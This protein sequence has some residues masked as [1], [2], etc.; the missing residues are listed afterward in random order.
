MKL[1]DHAGAIGIVDCLTPSA[2]HLP[3]LTAHCVKSEF[4]SVSVHQEK[5]VVVVLVDPN[6]LLEAEV[7]IPPQK[8]RVS[9]WLSDQAERIIATALKQ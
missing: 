8:R 5:D 4:G 1:V 2:C 7:E 3:Q 6:V 9:A